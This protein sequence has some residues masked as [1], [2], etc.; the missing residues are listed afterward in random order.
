MDNKL[1]KQYLNQ[2]NGM[3]IIAEIVEDLALN[4]LMVMLNNV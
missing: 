3:L 4:I 2:Q 1:K